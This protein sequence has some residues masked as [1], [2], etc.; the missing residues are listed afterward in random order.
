MSVCPKISKT[1][2]KSLLQNFKDTKKAAQGLSMNALVGKGEAEFCLKS[3]QSSSAALSVSFDTSKSYAALA[4]TE[5][6]HSPVDRDFVIELLQAGIFVGITKLKTHLSLKIA[7]EADADLKTTKRKE[8]L[9]TEAAKLTPVLT[10][11]QGPLALRNVIYKQPLSRIMRGRPELDLMDFNAKE[12]LAA[13]RG[14]F[15]EQDFYGEN[16]SLMG[17]LAGKRFTGDAIA[18]IRVC[19]RVRREFQT[20]LAVIC[21]KRS[22]VVYQNLKAIVLKM[23]L[24]PILIKNRNQNWKAIRRTKETAFWPGFNHLQRLLSMVIFH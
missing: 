22:T 10:L 24:S 2:K 15:H 12:H 20:T 5:A 6:D 3:L 8:F 17:A 14:K 13:V 11:P 4:D 9:V 21:R 7:I 18:R 19:W 1:E 16:S 23:N